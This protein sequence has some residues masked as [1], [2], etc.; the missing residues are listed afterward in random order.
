MWRE[1]QKYGRKLVAY[2]LTN[3]HFGNM[4]IRVG[5]K[6]L[7]TRSGSLL[8]EINEQMVVEVQL[9]QPTSFDIIASSETIVHRLI[10]QQTSALAII[11]VHSPF[12]VVAS[13]LNHEENLYPE[14]SET[15]YFLHKIPIVTGGI[16]SAVLATNVAKAL[17]DHKGVIVRGHGSFTVGKILEEAYVY[18]CS[19]E[20]AC[21]VKYFCDFGSMQL[22]GR[23]GAL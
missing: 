3:S 13:L 2:G 1:M 16:G 23:G 12:A 6:L 4:S 5:D 7:I 11:H 21:K 14:D 18:S 19:V 9:H 15:K 22:Q 20:H 10:Y 17:Q 8:D